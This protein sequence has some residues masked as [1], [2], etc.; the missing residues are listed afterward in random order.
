MKR[1]STCLSR[2]FL[3]VITNKLFSFEEIVPHGTKKATYNFVHE[4]VQR[5]ASSQ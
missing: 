5:M 4:T 1:W 3:K 2:E